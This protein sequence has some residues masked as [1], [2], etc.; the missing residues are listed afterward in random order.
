G[1]AP[2]FGGVVTASNECGP[3]NVTCD[4]G[5][6]TTTGC[7]RTQIFTFTATGCGLMSTC[8]RT[9]TWTVVT[10]P[11]FANCGQTIPLGCNPP[12]LPTCANVGTA[13]GFGGVVTASN[14]CGPVNVTCDAGTITATGCNRTQIFTFTATGCGLT[15]TCTR[16]FTWTVVT[17]P[18][19]ANC[20]QTIPLGCNPAVLPTCAT[21]STTPFGGAVTA[22]NE[23]GSVNVTCDAGTIT[24]IGCAR[25]QIF[26]FTATGCGLTSTCTR[27][28]TWTV[29]TAPVFAN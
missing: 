10:A 14:E 26:T 2:G 17:A 5:T 19:F 12:L 20:G 1:T 23:C 4:A 21:L 11:V 22:S 24:T 15:S 7:A 8:T 28:F 27:T 3:V 16:T 18:A 13:P 29:V 9:F 25:T 6:I